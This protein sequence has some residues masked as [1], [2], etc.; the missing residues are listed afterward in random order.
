MGAFLYFETWPQVWKDPFD[1]LPKNQCLENLNDK[2]WS[3]LHIS[4]DSLELD[5]KWMLLDVVCFFNEYHVEY[6]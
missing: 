3:G 1:M 2:L 4:F 5:K 6:G